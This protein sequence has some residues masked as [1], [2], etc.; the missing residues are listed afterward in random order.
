MD[1]PPESTCSHRACNHDPKADSIVPAAVA[2]EESVKDKECEKIPRRTFPGLHRQCGMSIRNKPLQRH[3]MFRTRQI[4]DL[5]EN[6]YSIR[7][8]RSRVKYLRTVRESPSGMCVRMPSSLITE[9]LLVMGTSNFNVGILR[10]I[11]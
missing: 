3:T 8:L 7:P 1:G 6:L 2:V 11:D 9:I 4:D 5:V 10:E